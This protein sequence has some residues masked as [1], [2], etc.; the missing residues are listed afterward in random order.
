MG[1]ASF[2]TRKTLNGRAIFCSIC[3]LGYHSEF[4]PLEQAFSDDGGKTW[5]GKLDRDGYSRKE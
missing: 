2:T 1:A 4:L 5:E 3:D